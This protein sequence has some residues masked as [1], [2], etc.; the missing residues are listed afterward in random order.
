MIK[1][2][3]RFVVKIVIA[4]DP[5]AVSL[6]EI[7]KE[8]LLEK[9]YEIFDVGSKDNDPMLF[10]YAADNAAKMIQSGKADRG[11]VLCGSGAG[12]GIVANKHK[13]VY[14]AIVE[15]EWAAKQSRI[16]NNA[17]MIALGA[18]IFGEGLAI[19]T[20]DAFLNTEWAQ[21]ADLKRRAHIE[22]LQAKVKEI[23]NRE[24]CT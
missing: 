14:C 13:G 18:R 24:F 6:K 10:M 15:S 12:V 9:G 5:L 20:V 1:S 17:N 11:I 21:G 8:H 2:I 4:S 7:I 22:I 19:D 3:G 16:I 23:E